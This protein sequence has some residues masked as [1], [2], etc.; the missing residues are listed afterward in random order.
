VLEHLKIRKTEVMDEARLEGLGSINVVCGRNN[1]GKSTI[2]R[3]IYDSKQSSAGFKVNADTHSQ[4]AHLH[5]QGTIFL[6]NGQLTDIGRR[7]EANYKATLDAR[8]I[9]YEDEYSEFQNSF[10]QGWSNDH[11]LRRYS[12][13][14]DRA[15]RGFATL[16]PARPQAVLVLPKRH[17]VTSV[18]FNPDQGRDASGAGVVNHLFFLKN[19]EETS[20]GS[21][22]Y[23]ALCSI[24]MD[25]SSGYFPDVTLESGNS[26]VLRFRNP[27]KKWAS[28]EE[29]GLGLQDL[30]V[31]L[32]AAISNS[33]AL[34]LL[35]E[36]ESHIHPEMQRR[37]LAYMRSE[38]SNQYFLTT[39]SNIFLDGSYVD[40]VFATSYAGQIAISDETTRAFLLSDLGYQVTDNLVSDAVVL[41][42]GP[43]D[44][45][46]LSEFLHQMGVT[47]RYA[48]KFWPLGGDIMDQL[49]LS[50]FTE[51]YQLLALID[52]DPG[53][54]AIRDRFV[55]KCED[56]GI[57]IHKLKRYALENYY[58]IEALREV[59]KGQMPS[60]LESLKEDV[61]LEKQLGFDVKKRGRNIARA[62]SVNDL[63]GTDLMQFLQQVKERCERASGRTE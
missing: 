62:M 18:P 42:E 57:H 9:W 35:E 4:A 10:E 1:S 13:D 46:V 40:K 24:F 34:I 47:D 19:Q 45:P 39:H 49:D 25:I 52:S 43:K 29:C 51:R 36:P 6:D 16:V 12:A 20:D 5:A 38:T 28:A 60:G 30:L 22:Q 15:K 31:I 21:I 27:N 11:Y 56:A 59:F 7:M 3:A 63:T 58:S 61:K 17:I 50:V 48:V 53:S 8:A 2:L 41:V 44:V 37:M 33:D 23:K 26:L 54:R 14:R 32:F 55:K